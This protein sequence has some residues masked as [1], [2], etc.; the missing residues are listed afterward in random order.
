MR[1]SR[2]S[3]LFLLGLAT[4]TAHDRATWQKGL[5]WT[6]LLPS[7][8]FAGVLPAPM[9]FLGGREDRGRIRRCKMK[10]L[11]MEQGRIERSEPGVDSN[12]DMA[13]FFGPS[14]REKSG[15]LTSL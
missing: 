7:R 15:S 6:L 4:W 13:T 2:C 11:S 9:S 5:N 8:G 10:R 14:P 3:T 1:H 12:M